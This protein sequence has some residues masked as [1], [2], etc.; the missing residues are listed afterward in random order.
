VVYGHSSSSSLLQSVIALLVRVESFSVAQQQRHSCKLEFTSCGPLCGH[1]R[2]A[3]RFNRYSSV[4]SNQ[5]RQLQPLRRYIAQADL[6]G[7][8][9]SYA[10]AQWPT[11]L[12]SPVFQHPWF[13]YPQPLTNVQAPS[14]SGR[15]P[16]LLLLARSMPC[17]CSS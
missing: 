11:R 15:Y 12:G 1:S 2:D 17:P 16:C 6:S 8:F 14:L 7:R 5:R 10:D 9:H 13:R 3:G 4:V